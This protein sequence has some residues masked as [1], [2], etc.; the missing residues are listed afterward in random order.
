MGWDKLVKTFG[1]LIGAYCG[2]DV[3]GDG[4]LDAPGGPRFSREGGLDALPADP[5][6]HPYPSFFSVL[7]S[8]LFIGFFLTVLF[9][10]LFL[11]ASSLFPTKVRT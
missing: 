8:S 5:P 7:A 11:C 4:T 9:C 6:S 1:G 10:P 3:E 2:R